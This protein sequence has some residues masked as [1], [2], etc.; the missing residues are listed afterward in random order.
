MAL[1]CALAFAGSANAVT[2][3]FG[4]IASGSALACT[5][6]EASLSVDVTEAASN[7]VSLTFSN[8]DAGTSSLVAVYL[9]DSGLVS[10]AKLSGG[11]GT[12]FKSGG[13]PSDLP[14]GGTAFDADFRFTAKKPS[15]TNGANGGESVTIVL[16]L[17]AG[18]TFADVLAA[19]ADGSLKIG[20]HI[21]DADPSC[22]GPNP[23]PGCTGDPGSASFVNVLP[24]PEPGAT[25]L[26][27]VA[28]LGL[29]LIGRR[30]A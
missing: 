5:V 8:S 13:K 14:G 12:D 25:A 30:R 15:D 27:S 4:C 22:V 23:G 10:K 24:V 20:A 28:C 6:G 26:A 21:S 17:K 9:D 16:K 19:L 18:V 11:A 3:G 1:V 29:A 7:K 2:L